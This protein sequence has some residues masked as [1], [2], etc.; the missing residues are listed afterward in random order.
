MQT[1]LIERFNKAIFIIPAIALILFGLGIWHTLNPSLEVQWSTASEIET[2]GFNVFR[3]DTIAGP[4]V[5][6]VNK[7]LVAPK[8]DS[9]TGGQYKLTDHDIQVGRTY[10]F[11]L[12]ELQMG[13][14]TEDFGPIEIAVNSI[15]WIEITAAV[16][17]Y[18][19]YLII[20]KK[21]AEKLIRN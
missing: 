4:F 6:Q 20:R 12:Q 1:E 10:F 8:G 13:G 11:L 16:L 17:I 5:Y 9:L 15:G 18:L 21:S 7:T 19:V 14:Q 3:A 2:L